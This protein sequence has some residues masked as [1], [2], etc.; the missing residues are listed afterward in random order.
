MKKAFL[1]NSI[2]T[3]LV[4][5]VLI[6]PVYGQD[7]DYAIRLRRDFGYGAGS[8]VRGTFTVSLV[9]DES[10]VVSVDFL[11]DDEVMASVEEQPFRYQFHTDDYGFGVHQ[12]SARVFLEDG[13]VVRTASVGL[14]FVSPEDE[15]QSLT[16]IFTGIGVTL[17]IPLVIFVLLQS[18]VGKRKPVRGLQPGEPQT[19]GVLGG[20]ICPKCR[21]HFPRHFWGVNLVVGKYDRCEHCGK[22]SITVRATPEELRAAEESELDL[23]Q[24]D[25]DLT[26]KQDQVKDVL[27]DTRYFDQL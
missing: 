21:R 18:R 22:W 19:Y 13:S 11:I 16:R 17:I 8:N 23:S 9:G 20:A 26:S 5:S 12:L 25:Q 15:R 3:V 6:V 4:F 14:I 7:A 2:I 1:I 10:G 24:P 27:E